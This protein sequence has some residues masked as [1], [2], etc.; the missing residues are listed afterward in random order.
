MKTRTY[1]HDTMPSTRTVRSLAGALVLLALAAAAGCATSQGGGKTGLKPLPQGHVRRFDPGFDVVRAADGKVAV[2]GIMK[3]SPADKAGLRRSAVIVSLDGKTISS[4]LD[5]LEAWLAKRN[6]EKTN[7]VVE[8]SGKKST[9]GMRADIP[10]DEP[11]DAL[12]VRRVLYGDGRV[13]LAVI[14]TG[15]SMAGKTGA[16]YEAWKEGVKNSLLSEHEA[17]FLNRFGQEK[18]FA[19]V[20]RYRLSELLKEDRLKQLGLVSDDSVGIIGNALGATHILFIGFGRYPTGN[21]A[22]REDHLS[23]RLV[24]VSGARV[25]ASLS[26]RNKIQ[27]P[28]SG[29]VERPPK[30]TYGCVSGDCA[31]G[32]GWY[33]FVNGES[34]E[35]QFRNGKYH[36]AGVYRHANGDRHAGSYLAGRRSGPGTYYFSRGDRFEG[37][38]LND[39]PHGRGTYHFRS[40]LVQECDYENGRMIRVIRQYYTK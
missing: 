18:S 27:V 6:G 23:R 5:V 4:R 30:K 11:A 17:M 14:V 35:G 2:G 22:Y 16:G 28:V 38:Y 19:L 15:V 12:A 31:N 10:F 13:N 1:P 9:L 8:T 34:Y 29:P 40:G 39:L 32:R 25:L 24:Q 26:L 7:L 21:P 20:D 37:N 3:D 33:V 36:G